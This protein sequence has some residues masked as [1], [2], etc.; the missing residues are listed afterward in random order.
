MQTLRSRLAERPMAWYSGHRQIEIR[1]L[2]VTDEALG[3][4]VPAFDAAQTG[5]EFLEG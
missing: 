5:H 2:H 3:L 1:A 4:R